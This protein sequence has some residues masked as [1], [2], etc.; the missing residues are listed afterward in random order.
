MNTNLSMKWIYLFLGFAL[1]LASCATVVGVAQDEDEESIPQPVQSAQNEPAPTA[2]D[3]RIITLLPKD[4]IPAIDNPSFYDVNE[5]DLEYDPQEMILG[6][7]FEG[8][9]RAY[10][11]NMLSSHE[12]VNDV[13]AG[14][15]IAV[16]W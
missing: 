10:S 8:E 7:E 12:I 2:P 15:P 16:T 9:A 5:A 1:I 6:V 11:V 3:Y 14:K 4:A 13:V